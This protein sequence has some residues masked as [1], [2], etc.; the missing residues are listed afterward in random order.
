MSIRYE[1]L[2]I[3][4]IARYTK[5]FDAGSVSFGVEYRL[6]NEQ[7]IAEEYGDDARAQFGNE[8]PEVLGDVINED[9]VSI[10]VFG[11]EDE[12]EYLRFDCFSD[13]PHYHY[14]APKEGH[15]TVFQ[16]DPVAEGPMVPWA[17]DRI[18]S[19][20]P[21]MLEHVGAKEIAKKV[22]IALVEKV[23]IEV[24]REVEA[25][26]RRGKPTLVAAA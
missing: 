13:Y 17:I 26:I 10:H 24:N 3:P 14:L 19:R 16:F 4:A 7:I 1:V 18:R 8:T 5:I 9:G 22:D 20:L 6:L 21:E 2:P 12:L 15:Q 11:A 23:L 25:A